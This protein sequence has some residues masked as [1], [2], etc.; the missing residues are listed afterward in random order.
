MEFSA[1]NK[2]I[3][4]IVGVS[5]C[6]TA[7]LVVAVIMAPMQAAGLEVLA[8]F[9]GIAAFMVLATGNREASS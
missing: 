9:Y 5:L 4:A 7:V 6:V 8:M 2:K 3:A 1:V